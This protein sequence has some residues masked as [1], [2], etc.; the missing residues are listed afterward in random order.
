MSFVTNCFG[1]SRR[2]LYNSISVTEISMKE[3]IL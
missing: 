2:L 1:V 3:N